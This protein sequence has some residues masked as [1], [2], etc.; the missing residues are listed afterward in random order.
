MIKVIALSNDLRPEAQ[1][2]LIHFLRFLQQIRQ[3][4]VD[5]GVEVYWRHAHEQGLERE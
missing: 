1:V 2:L 4:G 5:V 3:D